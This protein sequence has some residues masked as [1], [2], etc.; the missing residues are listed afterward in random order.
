MDKTH[1]PLPELKPEF[2]EKA[3]DR[4]K[5]WQL[6]NEVLYRLCEEHPRHDSDDSIIAKFWLI[7]RAYAAA[8]ERR[9]KSRDNDKEF[10][11]GDDFYTESLVPCIRKS[12]IDS[13][14]EELRS[15]NQIMSTKAAE[16][17]KKLVT[18]LYGIT[19]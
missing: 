17:H 14:F 8:V 9:K 4:F 1:V 11:V 10:Y 5:P 19:K 3:L 16:I 15:D 12:K 18:A 2:V 13:W 7:G 6:G